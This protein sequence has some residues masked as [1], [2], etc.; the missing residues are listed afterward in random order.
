MAETVEVTF[1]RTGSDYVPLPRGSEGNHVH[2]HAVQTIGATPEQVYALYARPESLPT[3]QEG[4]VSVTTTGEKTL[5]WIL[6]DPTTG[7]RTE[8]DAEIVE[9]VPGQKHVS[10][11]LNG[12]SAGTV[13]TLTLSEAPAGRGT[14]ATWVTDFHLPGGVLSKTIATALSRGPE[15]IVIENLR[16]LKELLEAGEIPS[17]EGQ[18]AGPRGVM[19]KWK[20]FMLGEN[21]PTPPGTSERA[22]PQDLPDEAS[23]TN[24]WVAGGV[25]VVAAAG[26]WWGMRKLI[27]D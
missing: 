12:P 6:Q 20:E 10:R 16:H 7:A 22:R 27:E 25:A 18:P 24:A 3:W 1:P 14:V 2:A 23:G 9:A 11:V 26:A 13:D 15:Q 21:M 4:V 17:V 8:F 5:H 19:G